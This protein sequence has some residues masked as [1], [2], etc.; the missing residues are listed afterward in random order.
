MRIE[1]AVQSARGHRNE[2]VEE[3]RQTMTAALNREGISADVAGREKNTY[4]IY[5][6]MKAQHKSFNE[7]MDVFGFRI[8]VDQPDACYRALGVVHNLFPPVA[9]RFKDYIAI[10]K[11][12]GYQ[13]LH[14]SL[15]G[16]HGVPIEV[17]IRTKQMDAVAE[18]GIAGHW[19]YSSGEEGFEHS[20]QRARR[21][22]Q[23]LLELQSRAGNSLKVGQVIH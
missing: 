4:S 13:S 12:N 14:T 11:A 17:Q 20:Q 3:I 6:K 23:D 10:P 15:Y 22:V 7:I 8:V 1:R 9:S 5:R 21:W 19:L 18:N 2:L 16:M